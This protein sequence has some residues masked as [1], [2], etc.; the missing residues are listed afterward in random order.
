MRYACAERP[1]LWPFI[2]SSV[3][4]CAHARASERA[5]GDATESK[6]SE[7]EVWPATQTSCECRKQIWAESAHASRHHKAHQIN[8]LPEISDG[9]AAAL[10]A[11]AVL[12]IEALD[13]PTR[14]HKHVGYH[15]PVTPTRPHTRV[16]DWCA[17]TCAPASTRVL[18]CQR[19]FARGPIG[20]AGCSECL[21]A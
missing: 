6:G 8:G 9:D 20:R 19:V 2:L 15:P 1:L 13:G 4:V 5:S 16:S 18:G 3:Y 7:D 17:C 11:H 14:T 21:S 12:R 10:L